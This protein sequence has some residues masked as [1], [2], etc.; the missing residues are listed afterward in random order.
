MMLNQEQVVKEI[1]A[2]EVKTRRSSSASSSRKER[3]VLLAKPNAHIATTRTTST[4]RVSSLA[5]EK[6]KVAKEEVV[7]KNKQAAVPTTG[8]ILQS[9][10]VAAVLK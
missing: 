9:G 10:S 3:N 2:K 1:K 8:G 5:R 6:V 7:V 4:R